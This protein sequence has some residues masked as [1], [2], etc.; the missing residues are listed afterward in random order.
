MM[1]LL[2]ETKA[3]PRFGFAAEAYRRGLNW[4]YISRSTTEP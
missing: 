3:N 4:L 2:V 1:Y